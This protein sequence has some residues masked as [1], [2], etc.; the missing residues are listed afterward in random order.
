[1]KFALLGQNI[2]KSMSPKLFK[3][4]GKKNG[5]DVEFQ[6]WDEP[7]I[8]PR[9]EYVRQSEFA[10]FMVT[11]PYKFEIIKY[12]DEV[13][14]AAKLIRAVN[15]VKI[16]DGRLIGSNSDYLGFKRSI[17]DFIY[18][19]RVLILGRSGAARAAAYALRDR[20]LY[21]YARNKD[22]KD[23]FIKDIVADAKFIYDLDELYD[24]EFINVINASSVGFN[25][26]DTII[27]KPF[28]GQKMAYDMIYTPPETRFLKIMKK[29]GIR[30]KNGMDMVKFQAEVGFNRLMEDI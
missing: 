25:S 6:L 14:E 3:E 24:H 2:K 19:G 21:F 1:M 10:G 28:V 29:N 27:K 13:N 5:V 26:D 7:D 18:D 23:L 22:E 11:A 30:T 20:E 16:K 8:K 15:T 9:M 17:D 4:L 12:L